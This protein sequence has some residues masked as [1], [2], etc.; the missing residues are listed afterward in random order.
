MGHELPAALGIRLAQP[1]RGRVIAIIGDGTYLMAPTELVTAAQEGLKV[2]VVLLVNGGY[3]S[4]H[5]LQR[6]A[7]GH[8]FATEFRSRHHAPDG[9]VGLVDGV[10]YA[11]NARSLGCAAWT[12]R[13]VEELRVALDAARAGC[14][15]AVIVCLVDPRRGLVG[16]GAWWDLGVPEVAADRQVMEHAAAAAAGRSRQRFYA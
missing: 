12:A 14:D 7:L 1:D 8:G 3:Q 2:T 4:I 5:A 13:S 10:D 15:P 16:A 6:S 9:L 11:A